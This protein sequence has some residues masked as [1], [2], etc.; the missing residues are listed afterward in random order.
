MLWGVLAQS[1]DT[2][3]IRKHFSNTCYIKAAQPGGD[4]TRNYQGDII[5]PAICDRKHH[6]EV[7]L[8]KALTR[9]S[10]TAEPTTD[11]QCFT[12]LLLWTS[13][14]LPLFW[15]LSAASSSSPEDLV[16]VVIFVGCI[17]IFRQDTTPRWPKEIKQIFS[18]SRS[19]VKCRKLHLLRKKPH[20][21]PFCEI[22]ANCAQQSVG[23]VQEERKAQPF[24]SLSLK[25]FLFQIHILV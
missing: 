7:F 13:Q 15:L 11:Q 24:F 22:A 2:V 21:S 9:T 14:M 1:S 10:P 4:S 5:T 25:I 23:E 19:V 3:K 16:F 18:S 12:N 6:H 20:F 8:L 17:D